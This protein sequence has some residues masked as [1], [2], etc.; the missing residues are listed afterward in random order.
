[1]ALIGNR[2]V[3]HKSPGRFLSGTVASIERSNFSRAGMLASRFQAMS[4]VFAGI[5]SGHLASSSWSLPRTAGAMSSTNEAVGAFAAAALA[6]GG[7]TTTGSGTLA[8]TVNDAEGQLISSGSGTA[9]MTFGASGLL[10]A[11]LAGAGSASFTISANTPTLGALASMTG[12]AT[13]AITGSLTPYAIGQMV[14]ST[15]NAAEVTPA[16]VADAVL[17]AMNATPPGVDVKKMN[18]ATV[19]GTGASGDP[20][21]GVGVSP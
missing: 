19:G 3:L 8:F 20:W 2:T 13:W 7:I 16:S 4:P 9:S 12:T 21:R 17:A 15:A 18:G 1:M 5:P 10:L 6:V 11:S 14:G